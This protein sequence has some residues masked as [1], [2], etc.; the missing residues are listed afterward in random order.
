MLSGMA[1]RWVAS[2]T[3]A[4]VLHI[5]DQACNLVG[6]DGQV[7]SLVSSDLGPGPFSILLSISTPLTQLFTA[8]A[9]VVIREPIIQLDTLTIDTSAAAIWRAMPSWHVARLKRPAILGFLPAILDRLDGRERGHQGALA[10]TSAQRISTAA[11]VLLLGLQGH[12]LSC[13][14]RGARLL[15]GLGQGLTPAGDDFLVGVL[16]AIWA[17]RPRD[18]ARMLAGTIA[19]VATPR[20]TLLSAAWLAAAARGE[21]GQP[22]HDL[23]D[24]IGVDTTSACSSLDRILSFGD[25][26][27][28]AALAGFAAAFHHLEMGSQAR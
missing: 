3:T 22:W 9:G 27:G 20:T 12:D 25:S 26:S 19:E 14:V 4:A 11:S 18:E 15:A 5:F 8:E 21:A 6:D 24:A 2:R 10:A 1:Q 23:L 28:A 13:C 17:S 16:F 7:V